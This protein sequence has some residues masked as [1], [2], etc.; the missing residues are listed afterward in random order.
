VETTATDQGPDSPDVYLRKFRR[1]RLIYLCLP[2]VP[3]L[4]YYFAM[5]AITRIF[6]YT[7]L[8]V[9]IIGGLCSVLVL[10]LISTVRF[11]RFLEFRPGQLAA[12]IVSLL[13]CF[14]VSIGYVL[15]K[16]NEIATETS[17]RF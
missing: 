13:V 7:S 15:Y 6:G 4:V 8:I 11:A 12:A 9:M 5:T 17:S 1:E 3:L 2:V 16:A 10:A 14:P